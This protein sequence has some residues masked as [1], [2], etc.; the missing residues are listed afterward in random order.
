VGCTVHPFLKAGQRVRIRGGCLE[1]LEC[2]LLSEPGDRKLIVSIENIERSICISA[3][4]YDLQ[5]I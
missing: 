1:G 2:I 3:C 4:D 5:P